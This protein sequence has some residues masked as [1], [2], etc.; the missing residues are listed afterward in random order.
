MPDDLE[1]TLV[2]R[3]ARLTAVQEAVGSVARSHEHGCGCMTCRAARGDI[4]ALM[5]IA[6]LVHEDRR[7]GPERRSHDRRQT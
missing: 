7:H 2:N 5:V 1:H 4:D 6:R 3:V